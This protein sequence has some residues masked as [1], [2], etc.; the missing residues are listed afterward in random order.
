VPLGWTL[1]DSS[2]RSLGTARRRIGPGTARRRISPGC[3]ATAV[4]RAV[5][6]GPA[7]TVV[8]VI[9]PVG[10]HMVATVAIE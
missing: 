1:P 9:V 3:I 4:A 7:D 8:V 6:I 10:I 5:S 2:T